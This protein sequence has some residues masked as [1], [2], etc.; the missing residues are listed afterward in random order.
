MPLTVAASEGELEEDS[1]VESRRVDKAREQMC[2]TTRNKGFFKPITFRNARGT[3]ERARA[4]KA[5]LGS[6]GRILMPRATL[7]MI[8]G[9]DRNEI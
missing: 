1:A 8:G 7:W 2:R 9:S 3:N 5:S 4:F 6:G